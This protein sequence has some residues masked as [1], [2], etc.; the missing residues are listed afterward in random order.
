MRILQVS[1]SDVAGGA[2]R[3]AKNLADAFRARGHE[4]WLAVGQKR[5]HDPNFFVIPND[6]ARNA[7]VRTIDDVRSHNE[8]FIRKLRGLGR[9][10]SLART[11]AEPARALATELGREDFEFP[12]TAQLLDLPPEMPDVVHLHNL[13]GGYFD[14]RVLPELS[15]R[16]PTILNV[17]DGW[18]MS[19]HCAFGIDCER[20]R[21]GCGD[22][23][24]LTL[25]PAVKRDATAFNWQRKR[26]I[27]ASS[28]LFVTTPSQW[29][30]DRVRESIIAPAAVETRVIP[31][32]VDTR[33]FFPG[34]RAAARAA[35]GIEP[36]ALVLLVAANGLRSNVWK[37]YRTLRGALQILGEQ[38]RNIATPI[39]VLAVGEDAPPERIGAIEL[40]F[41]PFQSDS[42]RLA[43]YYRAADIYLHAARVESFGNVLLET[44]ACGTPFVTTATGGIPEQVRDGETGL[45][46]K[47][48]DADAF[49]D[50]VA[51]L[52]G[53]E[54]LR[55]RLAA[56]GLQHVLSEFTVDIQAKRFLDWYGEILHA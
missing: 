13:H 9:A 54:A 34:D 10:A 25:F 11:L 21:T 27:L 6:A 31:N 46:V 51:K 26:G 3:S 53:D 20:W 55:E 44:R 5:T 33:T 4:S 24:D 35:I 12:G 38:S 48:G 2:E 45:L 47:P 19:G 36:D 39:I 22:C 8:P 18:L 14:L 50:A 1:T 37:D 42:A 49:A 40:R 15:H 30:M 17:R 23:P 7:V 32:G 28:R 41:V 52:I 43:D 56:A 29:M 16:V